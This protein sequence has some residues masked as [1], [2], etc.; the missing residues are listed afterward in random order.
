MRILRTYRGLRSRRE[1]NRGGSLVVLPLL[2]VERMTRMPS[3]TGD[4]TVRAQQTVDCVNRV[5]CASSWVLMRGTS[6]DERSDT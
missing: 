3:R 4:C 1:H 2:P 6:Y 5:P